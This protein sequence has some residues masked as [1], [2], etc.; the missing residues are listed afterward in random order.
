MGR[1]FNRWRPQPG[2]YPPRLP[3]AAGVGVIVGLGM[4]AFAPLFGQSPLVL[5]PI[6]GIGTFLIVL[7]YG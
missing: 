7:L 6:A 4:A 1:A 5:G 3:M 2:R